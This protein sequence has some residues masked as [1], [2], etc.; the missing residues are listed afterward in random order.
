MAI[1]TD[2]PQ[3]P[4]TLHAGEFW[5]VYSDSGLGGM[6]WGSEL[7]H[8]IRELYARGSHL[9][10]RWHLGDGCSL[11]D[12]H[13]GAIFFHNLQPLEHLTGYTITSGELFPT[14]KPNIFRVYVKL[15]RATPT[16][17]SYSIFRR[18]PE[19][20]RRHPRHPKA[21]PFA[22]PSLGWGARP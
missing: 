12:P 13:V 5:L 21:G 1:V 11:S 9:T 14:S 6:V 15:V 3:G 16:M 18:C 8:E 4:A 7:I 2:P 20:T 22:G 10:F 19:V 17:F